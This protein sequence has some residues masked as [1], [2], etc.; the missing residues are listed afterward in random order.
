MRLTSD[1]FELPGIADTVDGATRKKKQSKC[2]TA[3]TSVSQFYLKQSHFEHNNYR[4]K[5]ELQKC[6]IAFTCPGTP[7]DK[8]ATAGL[9]R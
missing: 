3:V 7:S 1:L 2:Q 6:Q 9:S 4:T 8:L 5:T